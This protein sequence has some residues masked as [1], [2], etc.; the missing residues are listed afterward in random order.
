MTK[1]LFISDTHAKHDELVKNFDL[2]EAD[3]L[4]HAGDISGYGSENALRKFLKWFGMLEQFKHKIFIAGNHDWIFEI[5]HMWARTLVNRYRRKHS[6]NGDINYLE[7]SGVEI[8]GLRFWGSPV[9][10][11]F[12]RW[13]F[14][15]LEHKQAERWEVIPDDIDVLITHNP[16]YMIRDFSR[17]GSQEHCGSESL[18]REVVHRIKPKIHV[19]GHIH[20]EYGISEIGETTFINAASIDDGYQVKNKPILIEI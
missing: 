11:P 2:P 6:A 15:K 9:S 19:F 5:D 1:L 3:F 13:A 12:G 14:M 20:S 8:D 4:V 18:Y 16:P 17:E 7:D 10:R